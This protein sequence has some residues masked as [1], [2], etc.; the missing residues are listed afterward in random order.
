MQGILVG[1]EFQKRNFQSI[2]HSALSLGHR[3]GSDS[4]LLG[5]EGSE[6]NIVMSKANGTAD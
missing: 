4:S 6:L 5:V 2:T 3:G 1:F